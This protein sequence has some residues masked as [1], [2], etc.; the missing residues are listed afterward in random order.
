MDPI[1]L[2]A[3]MLALLFLFA[4][5]VSAFR[6]FCEIGRCIINGLRRRFMRSE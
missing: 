6:G 1:T 4:G 3:Q 2:P 5:F